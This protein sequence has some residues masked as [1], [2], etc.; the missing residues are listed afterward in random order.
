MIFAGAHALTAASSTIRAASTVH[1]LARGCGANMIALRVLS[2][3]NAL[4]IA[5]EVGLVVGITPAII[6][7]G[8]ATFLIQF[9][10]SSSIIPQVLVFLY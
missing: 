3:S 6:P 10:K 1:F 8:S 9:S 4:K 7:I 2:A 5:V